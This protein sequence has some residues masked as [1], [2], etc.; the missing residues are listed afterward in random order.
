MLFIQ[1]DAGSVATFPPV[2]LDAGRSITFGRSVSAD[3]RLTDDL[4][5]SRMAGIIT[6]VGDHWTIS[7]TSSRSTY[8]VE[9]PEGGGEF[10]KVAPGE[11]RVPIGYGFARVV[12]PALTGRVSFLVWAPRD[13]AKREPLRPPVDTKSVY[14][15]DESKKYFLILVALCEPR[16]RDPASAV[17]PSVPS[18]LKRLRD[19]ELTRFAINHHINYLATEKLKVRGDPAEGKADWQRAAV[20]NLALRFDLVTQEHLAMLP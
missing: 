17:I 20:V 19:P 5:L 6:A 18:I 1:P 2:E 14:N 9:N 10:V 13:T 3:I 16:L 15:L 12:L 11:A 7:N 4:G 8:V